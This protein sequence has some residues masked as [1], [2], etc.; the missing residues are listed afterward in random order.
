MATRTTAGSVSKALPIALADSL[1]NTAEPQP[2]EHMHAISKNMPPNLAIRML[3][4]F[5]ATS[6]IF[7]VQTKFFRSNIDVA[8]ALN[9]SIIN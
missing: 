5:C 6:S 1:R 2:A 4:A 8:L 7:I 9:T 3:H